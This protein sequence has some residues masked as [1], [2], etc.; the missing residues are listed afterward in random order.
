MAETRAPSRG[1]NFALAFRALPADQR[2]A[3][4]A[5]HTFSRAV[6][7]CVDESPD[8]GRAREE[9]QMWRGEV[10]ACYEGEPREPAA[11]A[12]RPHLQRF[13]IPRA[14]LE[15]LLTGVEMDLTH[16]H[17]GTFEELRRYC[18]RVASVVGLICLR[19]FGDEEERGRAYAE[20]LGVA[21]Q[22]T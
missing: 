3:I 8:P 7:D 11:R 4:R 12:L 14:Y 2:E 18:Y 22:L 15:E 1:T 6:D 20:N 9:I 5:V 21:L 19:I 13:R 16:L 10:A 17:Y